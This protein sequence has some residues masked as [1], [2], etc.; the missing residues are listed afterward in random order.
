MMIF[1]RVVVYT[2]LTFHLQSLAYTTCR[3]MAARR[4]VLV[5]RG[6]SSRLRS[7]GGTFS[8][9]IARAMAVSAFGAS[10]MATNVEGVPLMW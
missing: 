9:S 10:T 6:A 8:W 1:L 3:R 7:F 2:S 5:Y 4:P